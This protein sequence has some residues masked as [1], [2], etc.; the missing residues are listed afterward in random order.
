[1]GP[2]R[3]SALAIALLGV[4]VLSGCGGG[5]RGSTDAQDTLRAVSDTIMLVSPAFAAGRTLPARFTCSG[6]GVSPPLNWTKVPADAKEL[7]VVLEDPDAPGGTFL[8]WM[9]RGLK[10]AGGGL[11]EGATGL[12][13]AQNSSGKK[14]YAPPCPPAGAAPHRYVFRVL[15]LKEPL[16]APSDASAA[17]IQER[18]ATLAIAQGRLVARFGR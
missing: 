18:A 13:T 16:V 2:T 14:G 9:V 8:H 4:A 1:M 17:V 10:P 12:K 7:V 11:P 5:V 15:A 6:A 3:S